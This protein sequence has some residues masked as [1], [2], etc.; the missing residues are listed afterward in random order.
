MNPLTLKGATLI[1]YPPEIAQ[2]LLGEDDQ[3]NG[4]KEMEMEE[5][6]SVENPSYEELL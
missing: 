4:E 3:Y 5:E 1:C 2:R 6:M